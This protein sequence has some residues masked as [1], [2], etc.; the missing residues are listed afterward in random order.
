MHPP[1]VQDEF[2]HTV[3]HNVKPSPAARRPGGELK[4]QLSPP[5]QSPAPY[6]AGGEVRRCR[7]TLR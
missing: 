6:P 2:S 4:G 1:Y 7:L 3:F 5:R